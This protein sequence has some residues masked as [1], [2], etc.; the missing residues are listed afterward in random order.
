MPRRCHLCKAPGSRRR[1]RWALAIFLY[2]FAFAPFPLAGAG[3]G[4]A[5]ARGPGV[6]QAEFRQPLQSGRRLLACQAGPLNRSVKVQ[7]RDHSAVPESLAT[8]LLACVR[9]RAEGVRV[10]LAAEG[11]SR[12][13][14]GCLLL[15]AGPRLLLAS[16]QGFWLPSWLAAAELSPRLYE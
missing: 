15:A 9:L 3:C 12:R 4:Q 10:R 7:L 6:P 1:S 11:R 13:A 2:L 8:R 5:A 16:R 14:R